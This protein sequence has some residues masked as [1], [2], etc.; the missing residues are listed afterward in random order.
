MRSVEGTSTLREAYPSKKILHETITETT[1]ASSFITPGNKVRSFVQSYEYELS[2]GKW[3]QSSPFPHELNGA[4]IFSPSPSGKLLA[5][6][7]EDVPSG[8]C[9]GKDPGYVIEIWDDSGLLFDQI[10]TAGVHGNI[11][12]DSW[13]GGFSWS[14]D[15]SKVVYVARKKTKETR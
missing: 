7:K 10:P 11:V 5:V 8:K 12:G 4:V 2:Q 14:S 6:V 15:E 13:F 3:C 1:R 9:M